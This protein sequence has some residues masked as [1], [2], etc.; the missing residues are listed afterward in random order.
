MTMR[1]SDRE[2]LDREVIDSIIS[3]SPI[4]R[5]G[6]IVDRRPYVVPLC[7]G[8]DGNAVFLHMAQVGKKVSGL[9]ENNQVCIEFDIP[10]DVLGSPD[11][12]SWSISYESVIAY[13]SV[14][15][16]DSVEEKRSA[17]V[18]IMRHYAKNDADWSLPTDVPKNMLV[19]KVHLNDI[20]GKARPPEGPAQER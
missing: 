11:A 15:F 17:L 13:G 12:C 5:L 14:E 4:C 19:V 8:Y 1:R 6:L 20:T 7:F 3:R 10:G 18:T 16:L 2:I 9:R